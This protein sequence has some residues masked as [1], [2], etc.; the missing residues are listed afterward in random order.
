MD[1]EDIFGLEPLNYTKNYIILITNFFVNPG[2]YCVYACDGKK[3][4]NMCRLCIN[5]CR[6]K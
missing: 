2:Y 1:K 6:C 4:C 5:H 3:A